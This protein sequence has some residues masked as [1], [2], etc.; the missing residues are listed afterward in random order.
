M[1]LAPKMP[2]PVAPA[3]MQAMQSP[4]DFTQNK[5]DTKDR[6]RRRGFYASIFTGPLG[7]GSPPTVTGTTGSGTGG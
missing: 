6:L 2:K 7:L 5:G 4:K 1:C 3:Q